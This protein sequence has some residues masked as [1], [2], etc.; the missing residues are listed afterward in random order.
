MQPVKYIKRAN[1][2]SYPC[3]YDINAMCHFEEISGGKSLAN[4]ASNIDVRWMRALIYA[5]LFC[6]ADF[7]NKK[8]F[9]LTPLD[10][11]RWEDFKDVFAQ[12][13]TVFKE[14]NGKNDDGEKK[15]SS[16]KPGE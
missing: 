1:G 5:G 12:C 13:L 6:G 9:L 16:D 3:R 10:I 15:E 4:G 14:M 2:E 8:D 11:G 7:T